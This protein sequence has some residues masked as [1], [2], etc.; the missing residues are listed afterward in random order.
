MFRLKHSGIYKSKT[1]FLFGFFC[2]FRMA[3]LAQDLSYTTKN[4]SILDLIDSLKEIVPGIEISSDFAN[5]IVFW[6][7]DFGRNQFGFENNLIFKTGKGFYFNYTAHVW[8]AMPNS[9]AKTDLGAGY[10]HQFTDRL[11]ASVGYERWIFNNGDDYVKRALANYFEANI[12]YDLDWINIEPS[13]YYMFGIED[14]YQ[15]D[16]NLN[17]EFSLFD[18][19]KSGNVS[20]KPQWLITFANRAFL[21][22]YSNYPVGYVNEKK[23]K[24][25][26]WEFSLP[27]SIKLKSFELEPNVH[28]N[29]P[30]KINN[31]QISSFFYFSVRVAYNLYFAKDKIRKLYKALK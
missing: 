30:F 19:L 29:I 25:I 1:K 22:I 5:K 6:G 24:L 27:I 2:L 20:I 14:I 8:S 9:Y 11:Y 21:P 16:I 15:A 10:E 31:E 23:I 3:G 4:D 26:D 13:F 17:S 28:Y 18:F 12:N 7:R